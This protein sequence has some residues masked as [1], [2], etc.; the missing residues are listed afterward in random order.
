[1]HERDWIKQLCA[2]NVDWRLL[3]TFLDVVE[4]RS[5]RRASVNGSA[6]LNTV[7]DRINRLE[8]AAGHT[9]VERSAGGVALT[10]EGD[11]VLIVARAMANARDVVIGAL[12]SDVSSA[13]E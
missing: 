13:A 7:R 11:A 2:P 1:M 5:L 3:Q 12:T 10:P 9:L 6:A 4:A 8:R